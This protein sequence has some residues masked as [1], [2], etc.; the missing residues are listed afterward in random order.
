MMVDI[1]DERGAVWVSAARGGGGAFFPVT[2]G[3]KR[4]YADV[5]SH[6][7]ERTGFK[8][9]LSNYSLN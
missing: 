3:K 9:F 1:G 7:G 4:E 6:G 8:E 2:Q 5:V